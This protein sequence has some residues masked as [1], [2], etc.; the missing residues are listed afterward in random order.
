MGGGWVGGDFMGVCG[1]VV[2]GC[3]MT[4]VMTLFPNL[5]VSL[6][7]S[8]NGVPLVLVQVFPAVEVKWWFL[9][10]FV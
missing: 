10:S 7:G 3:E 4:F 1:M 8:L 9:E 6:F 5:Q 2:G